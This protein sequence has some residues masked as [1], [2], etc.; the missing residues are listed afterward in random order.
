LALKEA[1]ELEAARKERME[2]LASEQKA[3]TSQ[4]P[5]ENDSHEDKMQYLISQ[6]EVFAHFLAGMC[7]II[8]YFCIFP[9]MTSF[10]LYTICLPAQDL[11]Q[12]T[13]KRRKGKVLG[14]V[15]RKA[16]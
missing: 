11:L 13:A 3:A 12:R 7:D 16:A 10:L 15:A 4:I 2:L 9:Q 8:V 5:T 6:S 14:T 1:K